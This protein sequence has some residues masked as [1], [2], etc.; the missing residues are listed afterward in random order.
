M[1]LIVTLEGA[2][3]GLEMTRDGDRCGFRFS[4]AALDGIGG[5]ASVVEVEPG[6]YSVIWDGRSYE[7]RVGSGFVEV[8]GRRYAARAADPRDFEAGAGA[9]AHGRTEVLA[10]MP[11]KVVRVLVEEGAE[12]VAGQGV[13]VV[14]AMKMQNEM[15]A[16][17]TGRVVALR[18]K[19]GE[20]VAAGD[21]LAAIE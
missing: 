2:Q 3:S 20:T 4:G 15:P 6:V 16:P 14:E 7:A 21:L 11:G 5:E 17:K 10:P 13:V 8:G 19:T 18:V 12:V 9:A 1:K